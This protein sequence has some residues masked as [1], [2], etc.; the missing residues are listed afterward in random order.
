[1]RALVSVAAPIALL[2]LVGM[3]AIMGRGHT[4]RESNPFA[5]ALSNSVAPAKQPV[6]SACS[7]SVALFPQGKSGTYLLHWKKAFPNL[8]LPKSTT[9]PS[10]E[11]WALVYNSTVEDIV[12][13][14]E[15]A[16]RSP[17]CSMGR[18]GGVPTSLKTLAGML[19]PWKQPPNAPNGAPAKNT[20]L[21]LLRREDVGSVLIEY[22]RT[23]QCSLQERGFFLA[24]RAVQEM[25]DQASSASSAPADLSQVP[26][27]SYGEEL[28]REQQ[29]IR[30]ELLLQPLILERTLSFVAN[31]TRFTPLA[32]NM[33][34]LE[35]AST[36]LRN[37]LAL[38]AEASACMPRSWDAR[39]ALR[40]STMTKDS[41]Q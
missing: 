27:N 3:A 22:L 10:Y 25:K 1:M 13:S 37:G 18:A 24:T 21:D 23:Y 16:Q 20:A 17:V 8:N 15:Q 7:G 35:R 28:V 40:N 5:A 30:R 12:S 9:K 36:D 11:D 41:D 34:C 33:T 14:V 19:A 39:G 38:A 32:E 6:L 31:E 29:F 4:P 26:A 2:A